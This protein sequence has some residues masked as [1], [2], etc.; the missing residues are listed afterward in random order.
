MNLQ[1]RLAEKSFG[2]YILLAAALIS[3]VTAVVYAANYSKLTVYMSWAAVV[4]MA[5]GAVVS[6]V[7][8]FVGADEIAPAVVAL[9][10]LIGL[11]LF[12]K[13]IYGYVAV[14]IVGI[15]LN[16]FD[17]KF[18]ACT[19]LFILSYVVSVVSIFAPQKK[20]LKGE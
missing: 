15:D 20:T 1:K 2:F 10:S 16:S 11:L 3:V 6:V 18:I 4:V 14:V 13:A 9:T 5:I 12:I 17:A 7:L 19:I 8:S